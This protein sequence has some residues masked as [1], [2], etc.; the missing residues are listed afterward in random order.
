MPPEWLQLRSAALPHLPTCSAA[1]KDANL[2]AAA[3]DKT[4]QSRAGGS[5]QQQI[6][7]GGMSMAVKDNLAQIANHFIP[8]THIAMAGQIGRQMVY[9]S[10]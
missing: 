5:Q 1:D 7:T 6:T 8:N 9:T 3:S 2:C 10:R 4:N